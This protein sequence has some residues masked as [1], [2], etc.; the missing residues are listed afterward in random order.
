MGF[1]DLEPACP[2]GQHQ[3][4]RGRPQDRDPAGRVGG[5]P[6][7]KPGAV[8]TVVGGLTEKNACFLEFLLL[9]LVTLTLWPDLGSQFC[10]TSADVV[11][12]MKRH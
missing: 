12:H 7:R 3:A 1:G 11:T 8:F 10:S 2:G 5:L 6:S 9:T 4:G